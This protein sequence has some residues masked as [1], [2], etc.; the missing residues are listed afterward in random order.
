MIVAR[1]LCGAPVI[2]SHRQPDPNHF[3]C[4]ECVSFVDAAIR[5]VDAFHGYLPEDG[6]DVIGFIRTL[7]TRL[8]QAALERAGTV[9]GAARLLGLNRTTLV[10]KLKRARVIESEAR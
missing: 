7:E 9:A 3:W 4:G 1:C 6:M 2:G 5:G 8:I 10:E